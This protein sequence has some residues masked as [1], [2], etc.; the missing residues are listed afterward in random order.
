MSLGTFP[1]LNSP[2]DRNRLHTSNKNVLN[3]EKLLVLCNSY[4]QIIPKRSNA[5]RKPFIFEELA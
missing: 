4:L 5:L 2:C 3:V 1:Q